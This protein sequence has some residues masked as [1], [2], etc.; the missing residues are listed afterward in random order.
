M[1]NKKLFVGF[2]LA[3]LLLLSIETYIYINN[4]EQKK[5]M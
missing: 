1:R 4:S 5:G 2:S 3:L